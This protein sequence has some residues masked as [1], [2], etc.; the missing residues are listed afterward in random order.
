MING[1]QVKVGDTLVLRCGG[2]VVCEAVTP[3]LIIAEEHW[4]W[5]A[6]G[7]KDLRDGHSSFLDIID[8]EPAPEPVVFECYLVRDWLGY[9]SHIFPKGSLIN[10][11]DGQALY[12]ITLTQGQPPKIEEIR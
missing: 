11:R 9:S 6:D 2:R 7:K 8:I 12:R 3:Y 1:K 10:R 4:Q 5:Y